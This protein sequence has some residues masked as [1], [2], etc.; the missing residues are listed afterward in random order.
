MPYLYYQIK[1]YSI[2]IIP[3]AK[4]EEGL[5]GL[6]IFSTLPK[7]MPTIH[8]YSAQKSANHCDQILL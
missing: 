2:K 3:S 1:D 6:A 5:I 7:L 4:D 8:F